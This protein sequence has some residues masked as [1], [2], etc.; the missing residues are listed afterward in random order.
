[1]KVKV[2]L[3]RFGL[4]F[5]NLE[6]MPSG[7]VPKPPKPSFVSFCA[8][9]VGVIRILNNT[10]WD[11]AVAVHCCRSGAKLNANSGWERI[12]GWLA[13]ISV[14]GVIHALRGCIDESDLR[15]H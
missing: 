14:E 12:D 10:L 9:Y 3:K 2:K 6:N 8:I 5:E 11:I 4:V 13:K 1:M 15:A 7:I